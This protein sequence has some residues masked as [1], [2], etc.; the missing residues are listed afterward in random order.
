MRAYVSR[1]LWDDIYPEPTIEYWLAARVMRLSPELIREHPLPDLL[2]E[3]M[4]SIKPRRHKYLDPWNAC[5]VDMVAD[6]VEMPAEIKP[7]NVQ[8]NYYPKGEPA[9]W[10]AS[11]VFGF[12]DREIASL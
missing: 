9:Y 5:R 2:Y 7:I 11:H 1:H 12:S 6:L 10:L 8:V 4:H 3:A